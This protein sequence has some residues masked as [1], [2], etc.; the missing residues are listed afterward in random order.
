MGPK[1]VNAKNTHFACFPLRH[2]L[3]S[4]SK[5][6][7]LCICICNS[8]SVSLCRKKEK[9]RKKKKHTIKLILTL[10]ILVFSTVSAQ[11]LAASGY[12]ACPVSKHRSIELSG[13]G[14]C[15]ALCNSHPSVPS[16]LLLFCVSQ[17]SGFK[18]K[19]LHLPLFSKCLRWLIAQIDLYL[20]ADSLGWVHKFTYRCGQ[21]RG[22]GQA[23]YKLSRD[24]HWHIEKFVCKWNV[25]LK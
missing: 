21:K 3:S 18:N 5:H 1:I 22:R 15:P 25:L 12:S 17:S 6:D 4:A 10:G 14:S 20:T 16:T 24:K 23:F 7:C 13:T 2:W 9:R 11:S 8:F 19:F